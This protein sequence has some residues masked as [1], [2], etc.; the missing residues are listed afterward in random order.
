MTAADA[1]AAVLRG[2]GTLAARIGLGH[3]EPRV[4]GRATNLIVALEPTPWVARSATGTVPIRDPWD[5]A[6]REVAL[7]RHLAAHQAP[8]VAPAPESLA[9][10]HRQDGQV[11]SL[12]QRV[13][14]QGALVDPKLAGRDLATCHAVLRGYRGPGRENGF[15][16]ETAAL[17]AHPQVQARARADDRARVADHLARLGERLRAQGPAVQHL[18]GD[19]HPRNV[20]NTTEGPRWSDWE[21]TVIAPREW[22]LACLVASARSAGREVAWS[23]AALAAYGEHNAGLLD[24]C[25][26]LRVL[27]GVA[28]LWLL[29]GEHPRRQQALAD[30]LAWIREKNP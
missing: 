20:L 12:W 28:W 6:W 27:F 13:E 7:A 2:A 9:G 1:E 18:H 17:L 5:F 11:I 10:P 14:V 29:A 24:L 30:R 4:I 22:D 23:Q 3:V 19:A 15:L 21:D 16:A 8:I 25:V 26:H